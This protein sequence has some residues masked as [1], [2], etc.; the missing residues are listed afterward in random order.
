MAPVAIVLTQGADYV[1]EIARKK[2]CHLAGKRKA[3][4]A[5]LRLHRLD[6]NT[7]VLRDHFLNGRNADLARRCLDKVLEDFLRDFAER[8]ERCRAPRP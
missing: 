8:M 4:C 2:D 6:R 1:R 3:R 5:Y 7:V